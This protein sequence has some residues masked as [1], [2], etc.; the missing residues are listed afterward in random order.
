MKRAK[1]LAHARPVKLK[2]AEVLH[3][4]LPGGTLNNGQVYAAVNND[5][6]PGL[7]AGIQFEFGMVVT[8]YCHVV[9]DV[10]DVKVTNYARR[11]GV[12]GLLMDGL[13]P[14]QRMFRGSD[15]FR[16]KQQKLD[17]KDRQHLFPAVWVPR[18]ESDTIKAGGLGWMAN[19]SLNKSQHNVKL[20]PHIVSKLLTVQLLVATR[21]ILVNQEVLSPYNNTDSAVH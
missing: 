21:R 19:T 13:G 11:T 7:H 15:S 8:A 17:I 12:P 6:E 9:R 10:C 1:R 5:S 4:E 2:E 16:Q 18:K 14:A 20:V 3:L